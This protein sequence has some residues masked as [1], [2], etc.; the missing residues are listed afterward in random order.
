MGEIKMVEAKERAHLVDL[1]RWENKI[2]TDVGETQ[3]DGVDKMQL[4]EDTDERRALVKTVMKLQ[5]P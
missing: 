5:V 1:H 4:C 2:K 3:C